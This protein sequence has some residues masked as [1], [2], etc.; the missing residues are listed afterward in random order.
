[1]IPLASVV[2]FVL[3]GLIAYFFFSGFIWGAGYYPTSKKEINKI[4]ELLRLEEG[5]ELYDLGSGFGGI[6][7][8]ISEKYDFHCVGVEIDPLKCW[9]MNLRIRVKKLEDKVSVIRGN[10]L[11]TDL[12]DA[13]GIFIFLSNGTK[14]MHRLQEKILR[15]TKPGTRI[16][17]YIHPFDSWKPEKV[18]G[19]LY[20]YSVPNR[21]IEQQLNEAN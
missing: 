20:L 5:S 19:K 16:V 7:I 15:E 9:W 1:M 21:I 4:V 11:S 12:K 3:S 10:L 2:L 18:D 13:D 6:I 17:S 8:S 14:I